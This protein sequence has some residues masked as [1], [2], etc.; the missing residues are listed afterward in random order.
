MPQA[1]G[2]PP[3]MRGKLL[4]LRYI[5]NCE[6]IT[7]ADAGKTPQRK[8]I[9]ACRWDHPRGCGENAMLSRAL[10]KCLGS[11]PRMRG[12]LFGGQYVVRLQRITPADAGKTKYSL[13]FVV[14]ISDHPRGC[15]ENKDI[16]IEPW[17]LKGSPPRMRGKHV[18]GTAK[19]HGYRI[20]PAD[21]GKTR[22]GQTRRHDAGDHPRGCGEN[23]VTSA[24]LCMPRGSPPRMRG[25]PPP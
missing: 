7:P 22:Y 25:K 5:L 15:G 23:R 16:V 20:T 11:P 24:L 10:L 21:A 17:M 2:S 4:Y 14:V 12:K 6:G 1:L 3:R 18:E 9:R 13:S 8:R 19:A